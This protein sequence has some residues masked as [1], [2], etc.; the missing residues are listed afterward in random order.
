MPF[1]PVILKPGPMRIAAAAALAGFSPTITYPDVTDGCGKVWTNPSALLI[2]V[3]L[4]AGE[5]SGNAWSYRVN[6]PNSAQQSTDFGMW[7]VNN[8][9]NAEY[10]SAIESYSQLNW[11]IF[12]DSADMAYAIWQAARKERIIAKG[13]P[14]ADW[15]PWHAY[16]GGGY[17]S[18][19]FGGKSWL[20][21]AQY[22]IDQMNVQLKARQ[23]LDQI[24]SIDLDP[25]VYW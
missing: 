14:G 20:D 9:Y 18:A 4:A 17:C 1:R 21:W 6:F 12:Y 24:A 13:E 3:A 19:R 22:G 15:L 5:S 11:A 23:T 8:I 10:F 7:E 2:A 25:L 16:S